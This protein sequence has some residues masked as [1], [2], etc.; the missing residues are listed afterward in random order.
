MWKP[1]REARNVEPSPQRTWVSHRGNPSLCR[2]VPNP[3]VAARTLQR[4]Q[5]RVDSHV[6]HTSMRTVLQYRTSKYAPHGCAARK[7]SAMG[8]HGH[9]GRIC[10]EPLS[11][12]ARL[13]RKLNARV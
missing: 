3:K 13:T 10:E 2:P 7:H 11:D 9:L 1:N 6:E 5:S 4:A 8:H 12:D